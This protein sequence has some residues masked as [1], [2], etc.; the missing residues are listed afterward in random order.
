VG[1]V[2]PKSGPLTGLGESMIRG[3][4]LAVDAANEQRGEGVRPVKLMIEDELRPEPGP[5]ET[6]HRPE[7]DGFCRVPDGKGVG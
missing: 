6:G 7:A 4:E 2:A 1:L 5:K 3:A